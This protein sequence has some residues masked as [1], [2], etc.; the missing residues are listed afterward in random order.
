MHM[1]DP[2]VVC[3]SVQTHWVLGVLYMQ[4]KQIQCVRQLCELCVMPSPSHRRVTLRY[5]D[6]LGSAGTR[7]TNVL[8]QYD[9]LGEAAGWVS[10]VMPG[11]Y[12]A[13]GTWWMRP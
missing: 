5:L 4:A 7:A 10:C 2:V 3:L 12:V 1:A 9:C 6:S 13:A 8:K 11:C